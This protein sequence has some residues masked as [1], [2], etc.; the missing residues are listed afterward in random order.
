ML[1]FWNHKMEHWN[2]LSWHEFLWLMTYLYSMKLTDINRTYKY[3]IFYF[4]HSYSDPKD[5]QLIL[6]FLS[7]VVFAP[8]FVVRNHLPVSLVM[9]IETPRLKSCQEIELEGQG[10]L[11]QLH[12]MSG[13][14]THNITFKLRFIFLYLGYTWNTSL[15]TCWGGYVI[16]FTVDLD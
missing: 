15:S 11:E 12:T 10:R 2:I 1:P 16:C 3:S 6:T 8:L 13:D 14:M 4:N 9:N 5:G 7:Q